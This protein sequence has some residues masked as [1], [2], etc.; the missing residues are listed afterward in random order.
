[1]SI[2]MQQ[3]AAVKA[4]FTHG[5]VY[6]FV[7][8]GNSFGLVQQNAL[9]WGYYNATGFESVVSL[10]LV[11]GTGSANQVQELYTIT[12]VPYPSTTCY[13]WIPTADLTNSLYTM[14]FNGIDANGALVSKD[15]TTWFGLAAPGSSKYPAASS[16]DGVIVPVTTTARATT[17][18]TTTPAPSSPAPT[19]TSSVSTVAS[20]T[21]VSTTTV[22][23]A[24]TTP[25]AVSSTTA[26]TTTA[27]AAVSSIAPVATT[28]TDEA[29]SSAAPTAT[30]HEDDLFTGAAAGTGVSAALLTF[31]LYSLC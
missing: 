15:Y 8:Q 10:Q 27:A 22:A 13:T 26:S 12:T 11:L 29:K 9:K 2:E 23:V 28:T 4:G 25:P 5:L 6:P 18:A 7:E 31:L 16:C 1:M 21:K 3:Q 17:K 20:T 14:V 19:A 24:P 30:T